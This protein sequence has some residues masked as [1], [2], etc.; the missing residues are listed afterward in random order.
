MSNQ[1]SK[2]KGEKNSF[3]HVSG[4]RR[5]SI[6]FQI[7][8]IGARVEGSIASSFSFPITHEHDWNVERVRERKMIYEN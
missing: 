3:E 7:N 1:K 8:S 4:N 5:D 6:D 2:L